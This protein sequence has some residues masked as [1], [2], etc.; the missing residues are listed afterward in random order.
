MLFEELR[1][2]EQE[3]KLWVNETRMT[4]IQLIVLLYPRHQQPIDEPEWRMNY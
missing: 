3:T 2:R 1:N 4:R